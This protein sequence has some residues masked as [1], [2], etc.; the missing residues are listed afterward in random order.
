LGNNKIPYKEYDSEKSIVGIT[1]MWTISARGVPIL[2]IGSK[3]VYGY[4]TDT[5][6]QSLIELKCRLE[7]LD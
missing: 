2:V 5:I 6:N 7:L 1:S 3:M 4:D